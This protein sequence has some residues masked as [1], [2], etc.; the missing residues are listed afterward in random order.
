[1]SWVHKIETVNSWK[2]LNGTI[3]SL[4]FIPWHLKA[5]L[6]ILRNCTTAAGM[7]ESVPI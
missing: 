2:A 1:M 4:G 6:F 7:L 5:V 3:S